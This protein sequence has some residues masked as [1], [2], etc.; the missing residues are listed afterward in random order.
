M[1][2]MA[3][4]RG[5]PPPP[6]PSARALL[7]SAGKTWWLVVNSSPHFTGRDNRLGARGAPLVAAAVGELQAL[8]WLNLS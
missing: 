7:S 1:R 8:R 6:P 2:I 3:D 5:I 4:R